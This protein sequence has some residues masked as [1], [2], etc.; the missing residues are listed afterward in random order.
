MNFSYSK[1]GEHFQLDISVAF[2]TSRPSTTSPAQ[3][4]LPLE[5]SLDFCLNFLLG[6]KAAPLKAARGGGE[7]GPGLLQLLGRQPNTVGRVRP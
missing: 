5:L 7:A 3:T 4:T 2:L 6:L 1:K